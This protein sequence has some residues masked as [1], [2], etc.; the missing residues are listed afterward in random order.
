VVRQRSAK[1]PSPVQIRAAPPYFSTT[2]SDPD[3]ELWPALTVALT[4][5]GS[6]AS[7]H[8][9]CRALKSFGGPVQFFGC[10]VQVSIRHDV[11]AFKYRPRFVSCKPHGNPF[12]DPCSDKVAYRRPARYIE[13]LNEMERRLHANGFDD[14]SWAA[15]QVLTGSDTGQVVS[16]LRAPTRARVGAALDAIQFAPWSNFDVEEGGFDNVRTLVHAYIAD[17]EIYASN[18]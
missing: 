17:C 16:T 12:G 15:Y 6:S 10:V 7:C 18:Q 2:Y 1:P 13:L 14:V 9:E 8:A 5:C 4:I 11:V 3:C